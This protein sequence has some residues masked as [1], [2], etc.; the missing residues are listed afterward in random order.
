MK[1]SLHILFEDADVLV[2]DKPAGI[3]VIPQRDAALPSLQ[4]NLE[5][6]YGKLFIVHRLDKDTSGVVCF[7]RNE[8]AHRN[9][10]MQFEQHTVKKFYTAIVH[11][12]MEKQSGEIDLPLAQHPVKPNVMITHAKGKASLSLYQVVEQF[13]HAALLRVEIRTGRTHQVRVHLAAIGHA[14]LVDSVYGHASAFYL[15]AVKKKYK[16]SEE[17]RPVISRLTL[18]AAELQFIHPSTH[19]VITCRAP[20]PDDLQAVIKLLRKYDN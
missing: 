8:A 15:S 20:L 10:S 13:K 12:K 2:V 9:I 19:E 18:H 6:Q 14:L 3:T 5:K 17:E 11:G 16:S 1:N 7:A 4:K